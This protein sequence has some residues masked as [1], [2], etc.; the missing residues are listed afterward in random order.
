MSSRRDPIKTHG[1]Q[2]HACNL[3]I[4]VFSDFADPPRTRRRYYVAFLLQAASARES[5]SNSNRTQRAA[6]IFM[7][8]NLHACKQIRKVYVYIYMQ[9]NYRSLRHLHVHTNIWHQAHFG[10]APSAPPYNI[11]SPTSMISPNL[12]RPITNIRTASS[13]L[14]TPTTYRVATIVAAENSTVTPVT[15]S[16]MTARAPG[17][18]VN[19]R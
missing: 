16:M 11:V 7:E 1:L 4:G 5:Y 2:P 3:A 13:E 14:L 6:E 9:A 10:H 12:L 8:A 18:L 19:A 17:N 15:A